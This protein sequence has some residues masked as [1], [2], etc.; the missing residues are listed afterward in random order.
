MTVAAVFAMRYAPPVR[1]RRS[2]S[3]AADKHAQAAL[4]IALETQ[5]AVF[6]TR[7]HQV[8]D[9]T[10]LSLVEVRLRAL[11]ELL[12]LP[13]IH[14]PARRRGG[15]GEHLAHQRHTV[16]KRLLRGC[17]SGIGLFEDLAQRRGFSK[18]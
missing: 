14:R 16:A 17:W 5:E 8:R 11:E 3:A 13:R 15:L 4:A 18:R 2:R 10:V 1:H 7:A 12:E 9:R 6:L